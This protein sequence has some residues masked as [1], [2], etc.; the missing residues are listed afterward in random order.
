VSIFQ[1]IFGPYYGAQSAWGFLNG[2]G[3]Y[4]GQSISVESALGLVP[5]L[6]AVSQIAGAVATLPLPVYR[7]EGEY[8]SRAEGDHS[9]ALLHE[10]P[11][12]EM[13]A[14]ELWELVSSHIDLWGNAFVWK[15]ADPNYPALTGALWPLAP[16]RVLVGRD[17]DGMREFWIEGERFTEEQI[18]H[19][20]GLSPDGLVGY[21]P[22]QLA[23]NAVANGIG[24]DKFQGSLLK[25]EGKPSLI[26]RHPNKLKPDA[27]ERLKQSWD[28]IKAGGTG[29][30]EEDI[31]IERW[32]MPLED[33]QFIQQQEFT[34][35]RIAQMFLLR[36]GRLGAKTGDSLTYATT[37][38]DARDFVT[39]TLSRRLKRIENALNRDR[40]IITSPTL[41]CEFDA[42]ALLRANIK[43]RYEAFERGKNAGFLTVEDIRQKEN[44]P[45]LTT[46]PPPSATPQGESE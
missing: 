15:E 8:R 27:Q 24:L 16:E 37:E 13:A 39:F 32:T 10:Q 1:R 5:V 31:K 4:S 23:R 26:L 29:V 7:K 34:D 22:I 36:P 14:D 25:D 38:S 12:S 45:K 21:S 3:T 28:A 2:S 11:N 9:W 41:F 18:L 40:S 30:L 46:P 19:I 43:E 17:E 33:A 42:D 44:L 6:N 35:K 20:R